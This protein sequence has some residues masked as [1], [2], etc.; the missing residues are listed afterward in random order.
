[1]SDLDPN[2]RP[3]IVY[4]LEDKIPART[5]A[6]VGFQH[7]MAM[8]VGVI[9]MP[10]VVSG[11]LKFSLTDTAYLVSMGLFISGISTI[12]QT[13]GIGPI[14][15]RLLAIQGTSFAFLSPLILA[16]KSGGMALMIG[17]SLAGAPIEAILSIF[18]P[19]LRKVFTPVVTGVVVLLIG[20]SLVPVGMKTI[21]QGLNPSAP[22]WAGVAIACLVL[23][24]VLVLNSFRHPWTRMAAVPISLAVGWL[25][26]L[27]LGYMKGASGGDQGSWIVVP[28]PFK[29]G[30]AFD[31]HF[32]LP[33][34]FVYVITTL[35]SIGDITATS[36]LSMEPISGPRYWK[37]IR[38]GVLADSF[39]SLLAAIFNTFP[40]TTF[41][42]NNGVIQLTGVASR[43]VGYWVGGILAV[44]GL[45]PSIGRFI[46]LIPGPVLGAVTLLLFGMVA[47]AGV[48]ILQQV[49]LNHRNLL[50]VATSMSLGLGVESVPEVLEPLPET[51]KL[52]F[53][54]A[55]TTGGIAALLLNTL[56]PHPE[57]ARLAESDSDQSEP[58]A[59]RNVQTS[60]ANGG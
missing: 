11:A 29:Y 55:V 33:F 38:G 58:G 54:S 47:T 36:Q 37:R 59:A 30:L 3:N 19:K 14:G 52:L 45:F 17:M 39:N 42:Q 15:S 21:A 10:L 22:P 24:I 26:C 5:A 8:F 57:G 4:Q 56:M 31:I 23:A 49:E 43:R 32:L 51:L 13:G 41:A 44:L 20:A 28:V 50:I 40:N 2:Y 27:G 16:G 6:F 7:V 53:S 1:M 48:R 18:L 9:T 46:A 35:E 60:I 12:I 34:L 25:I